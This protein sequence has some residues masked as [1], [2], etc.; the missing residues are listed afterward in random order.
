MKGGR[1]HI[2]KQFLNMGNNNTTNSSE[3]KKARE[4]C[5]GQSRKKSK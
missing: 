5:R 4:Q 3:K 2:A 1:N